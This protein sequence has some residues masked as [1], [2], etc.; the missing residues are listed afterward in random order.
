MKN[1]FER[2]DWP[3]RI[4]EETTRRI[5]RNFRTPRYSLI[6]E[7]ERSSRRFCIRGFESTRNIEGTWC[8]FHIPSLLVIHG[9]RESFARAHHINFPPS[10]FV[11]RAV[12]ADRTSSRHVVFSIVKQS[13]QHKQDHHSRRQRL[14]D[15]NSTGRERRWYNSSHEDKCNLRNFRTI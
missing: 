8:S 7:H 5:I 15:L 3:H 6:A 11:W 14:L 12:Q 13:T 2:R 4:A 10:Y 1:K 9:R